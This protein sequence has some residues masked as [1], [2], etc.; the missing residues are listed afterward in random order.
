VRSVD[1]ACRYGGD[2]FAVLLLETSLDRAGLVAERIRS[3]IANREYVVD[4]ETLKVTVSIG[5]ATFPEHGKTAKALLGA[6]DKAM[7][8]AKAAGKNAVSSA[9]LPEQ[10]HQVAK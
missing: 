6:S 3:T 7:Y 10:P 4:G 2:E 5:C 1:S 9:P 8:A